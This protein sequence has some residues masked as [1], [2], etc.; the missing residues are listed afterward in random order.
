YW[1]DCD[2]GTA[3]A[4]DVNPVN[5]AGAST[6]RWRN[7]QGS[8]AQ[9]AIELI[10]QNGT[11]QCLP[12]ASA[13]S[14]MVDAV[15]GTMQIRSTGRYNGVRR[16][17]VAT[18]RRSGFLD[19]LYFTNFETQ[20]PQVTG[21]SL[22]CAALR[23]AGRDPS[24]STIV[25]GT[26]DAVNGPFHTN[27]DFIACGTPTFGRTTKD[28]VEV[29]APSP[30]YTAGCGGSAAPDFKSPLQFNAKILD[31][32]ASNGQLLNV[33]TA[34]GL[35]YSGTTQI[36]LKSNGKMD[37][38]NGGTTTV[39]VNYPANGVI[40]VNTGTGSNCLPAYASP[41]TYS[42]PSCTANVY[43][44]GTYQKSLTIGSARDIIVTGNLTKSGNVML[45]LI[46]DGFV[47]VYH[48][49]SGTGSGC[50]NAASGPFGAAP[51]TSGLQI[52]AAILAIKHSFIVDN[53]DCG[54]NLGQLTV[55]GAIAQNYRGPV[56]LVSGQG[57]VKN[58][59]YDDRFRVANP[60]YFLDP[61]Q[62]QWRKI[63]YAEQVPARQGG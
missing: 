16:T 38:T 39:D 24:C 23:R 29:S 28:L 21:S 4:G 40:Y 59:T 47:R 11:A 62:S 51:G 33:A 60:P 25:F 8:T 27:D 15:S 14:T 18:L 17:V 9:Y 53:Y 36:T 50:T 56:G 32:P 43:V 54:A 26:D 12:G 20:D 57:Y 10:P 31:L 61:V 2:N 46:P 41:Q 3:P 22:F 44:K 42:E 35:V 37:V 19:F 6:L 48:P 1:T 45:G 5:L 63:R 34:A 7:V 13:P 49:V 52:D 55:T 58:Y 30:G